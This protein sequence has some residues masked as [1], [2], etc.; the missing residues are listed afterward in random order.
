MDGID[1]DTVSDGWTLRDS[2]GN[3]IDYKVEPAYTQG[4]EIFASVGQCVTVILD[5]IGRP[6]NM[7]FDLQSGDPQSCI[8]PQLPTWHGHDVAY[9][10]IDCLGQAYAF[11]YHHDLIAMVAGVIYYP[12]LQSI[13]PTYYYAWDK[14]IGICTYVLNIP[15]SNLYK[16]E[17]VPV[18]VLNLLPS[19]D[20][21]IGID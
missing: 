13:S 20:Y 11:S 15:A 9:T 12:T 19:T 3:I 18:W 2:D 5:D 16:Y 7:P 4:Y 1:G 10:D 21:T 6:I 14:D 8:A 17:F